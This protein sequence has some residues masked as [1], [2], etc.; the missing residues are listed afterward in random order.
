MIR[1]RI[2]DWLWDFLG[3]LPGRPD[4]TPVYVGDDHV[5]LLQQIAE[6]EAREIKRL[7]NL[8]ELSDALVSVSEEHASTRAALNDAITAINEIRK[9]ISGLATALANRP[10]CRGHTMWT[11]DGK[12]HEVK[13]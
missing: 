9:D 4:D 5:T 10:D 8:A 3:D 7:Q 1:D 2:R 13:A 6:L 12:A 11:W